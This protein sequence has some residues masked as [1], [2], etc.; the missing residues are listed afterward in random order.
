MKNRISLALI[1]IGLIVLGVLFQNL[2]TVIFNVPRVRVGPLRSQVPATE[3]LRLFA[4]GD[5]GTGG[6]DQKAVAAAMEARCQKNGVDGLLF[7]GDNIY[8]TGVTDIDDPEWDEKVWDVYNT[9]CLSKVKI[10][11]VLGNHDYRDSPAAQ[12]EYSLKN[13]RWFMPNRFYSVEFGYLLKLVAFDSQISEFCF[14]DSF[15]AVDFMVTE[16]RTPTTVWRIVTAHHPLESASESGYGHSGGFRGLFLKPLLCNHID[17]YLAGH[18]HHME[19]RAIEDCRMDLFIS[20]GGGASLYDLDEKSVTNF[21]RKQ[22]GF[23]ELV[24]TKETLDF[25]FI[26][27]HGSEIYHTQKKQKL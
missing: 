7:L 3:T 21:A 12:I 5:T 1:L 2:S 11:P 26:D 6:E 16:T 9:P 8:K 17:A 4:L 25:R 27:K 20:G 24:A 18:A 13:P 23:L 22:H 19:H 15:C 10:Y 14:N